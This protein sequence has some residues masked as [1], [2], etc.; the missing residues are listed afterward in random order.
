MVNVNELKGCNLQDRYYDPTQPFVIEN[1]FYRFSS[2]PNNGGGLKYEFQSDYYN[3]EVSTSSLS[4]FEA[5]DECFNNM[6]IN[7]F[8][9]DLIKDVFSSYENIDFIDLYFDLNELPDEMRFLNYY[10]DDDYEELFSYYK[11]VLEEYGISCNDD[12]LNYVVYLVNSS[13]LNQDAL[14]DS[15]DLNLLLN[16]NIE[17]TDNIRFKLAYILYLQLVSSAHNNV[18]DTNHFFDNDGDP[19]EMLMYNFYPID[20]TL[21]IRIIREVAIGKGHMI[22]GKGVGVLRY[23]LSAKELKDVAEKYGLKKSGTKKVLIDRIEEN[24]TVDEINKEFNGSRFILTPEGMRFLRKFDKY[25]FDYFQSMP[26][27]FDPFELEILCQENPQYPIEDIIF[28]IV[29]ED[30]C[31]IENPDIVSESSL[32]SLIHFIRQKRY[33]LAQ[34]F[35]KNFPERAIELYESCLIEQLNFHYLEK[36]S[37]PYHKYNM[38]DRELDLLSLLIDNAKQLVEI[39]TP[40]FDKEVFDTNINKILKLLNEVFESNSNPKLVKIISRFKN[41]IEASSVDKDKFMDFI[42]E[43]YLEELDHVEVQINNVEKLDEAIELAYS[44][45]SMFVNYELDRFINELNGLQAKYDYSKSII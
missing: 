14:C 3:A 8:R 28:A 7:E 21:P 27:C 30:W 45:E 24:L 44:M 33:Y 11:S 38:V 10:D 29:K 23:R 32:H 20:V 31:I 18:M 22:D 16:E 35:E 25:N 12:D 17:N 1:E 4:V 41:D 9:V 40:K 43:Y 26:E 42:P 5:H 36:L 6:L 39:N 37:K 13:D 34:A 2:E 15:Y 19:E